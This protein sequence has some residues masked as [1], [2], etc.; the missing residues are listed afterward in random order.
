MKRLSLSLVTISRDNCND[1]EEYV[2]G[3]HTDVSE[4]DKSNFLLLN[5][6][7]IKVI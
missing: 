6:V 1:D 5:G 3:K 2:S 4:G 7:K